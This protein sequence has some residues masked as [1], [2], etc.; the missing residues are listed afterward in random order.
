[1]STTHNWL[2]GIAL[3]AIILAGTA[4][5]S[6]PDDL[7][8]EQAMADTLQDAQRAAAVAAMV[9]PHTEAV[10]RKACADL[11]ADRAWVFQT[12]EGEWVCRKGPQ[13]IGQVLLATNR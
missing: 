13:G 8:T 3:A 1:M 11:Y 7:A 5:F 4:Q 2:G 10:A 6:G 9:N 12:P